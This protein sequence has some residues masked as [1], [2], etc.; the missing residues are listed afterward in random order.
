MYIWIFVAGIGGALS[1]LG[2]LFFLRRYR[3]GEITRRYLLAIV[4]GYVSFL[5]FALVNAFHPD[6]TSG[7]VVIAILLPA[8]IAILIVIREHQKTQ[9]LE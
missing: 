8:F 9:G 3:R 4:V 6:L 2:L 5:T 1:I 7:P